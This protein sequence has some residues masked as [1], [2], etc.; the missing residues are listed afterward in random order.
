MLSYKCFHSLYEIISILTFIAFAYMVMY[1]IIWVQMNFQYNSFYSMQPN[2]YHI[3]ASFMIVQP[4]YSHRGLS[5][6]GIL[7]L[8]LCCCFLEIPN[9]TPFEHLFYK[10]SLMEQRNMYMSRGGLHTACLQFFNAVS[11]NSI[12]DAPMN[13]ELQRTHN[14]W[15]FCRIKANMKHVCY[16]LN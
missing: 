14:M 1:Y 2:S 8:M 4:L 9:N 6:E 13:T 7:W 16:N 10:W 11:T 5:S 15:H 3:I 12:C